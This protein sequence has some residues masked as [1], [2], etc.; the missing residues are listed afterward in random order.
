M[1]NESHQ[2]ILSIATETSAFRNIHIKHVSS[3]LTTGKY[4]VNHCVQNNN[5]S[6]IN[7]L[8][9]HPLFI[10]EPVARSVSQK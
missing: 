3:H 6:V 1:K 7:L 2:Y 10:P 5:C 9:C 8:V 4:F